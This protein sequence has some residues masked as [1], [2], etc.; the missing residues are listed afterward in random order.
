MELKDVKEAIDAMGSN[1][2]EYK[3]AIDTKCAEIEKTGKVSAET[4]ESLAKLETKMATIEDMKKRFDQIEAAIRA[5]AQADKSEDTF[6]ETKDLESR[7]FQ[8]ER[9]G[10]VD[11]RKAARAAFNAFIKK[12]ENTKGGP[13]TDFHW[14]EGVEKKNMSIIS[15]PDGGYLTIADFSGRIV[16]RIFETSPMRAIASVQSISSVALE[17][18]ND[19]DQAGAEWDSETQTPGDTKTPQ[20]GKWKI[21][22]WELRA[23]TYATMQFLEDAQ[24]DVESWLAMKQ[25]DKFARTE[26]TAFCVGS[27]NGQPRGFLSYPLNA[28]PS[29]SGYW[30]QI[31]YVPTGADGAFASAPNSGDCL[32]TLVQS[33][34]DYYRSNGQFALTRTSLGVVRQLKDSYGRYLWEPSLAAGTPSKLLGFGVNEFADMPEIGSNAAAIAFGDFKTGYQICDRIGIATLRDPYTAQP[35]IKFVTRKRTG[36]D[37]I[38]F[39]AIKVLKFSDS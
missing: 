12:G 13:G 18:M 14:S 33:L 2:N 35:Y 15:D 20:V 39:D 32:I 24:I 37:V 26:N 4:K 21:P 29:S 7:G 11:E 1:W 23:R 27:G 25:A 10:T 9:R 36:G 8:I 38:D 31:Q 30:Q 16:K 19:R 3:K 28:D 34:F 17:G 5:S 22:V 6:V